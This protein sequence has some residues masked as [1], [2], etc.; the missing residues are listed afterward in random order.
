[1]KI[2]TED[3]V[4][5]V[6]FLQG[7]KEC[8]ITPGLTLFYV[9]SGIMYAELRTD[10][11]YSIKVKVAENVSEEVEFSVIIQKLLPLFSS[12]KEDYFDLEVR[13]NNL[14]L[15]TDASAIIALFGHR[16]SL[17]KI[18]TINEDL[19][20]SVDLKYGDIEDIL[21][22]YLPFVSVSDTLDYPHIYI[23]DKILTFNK[24][25]LRIC[26]KGY[27]EFPYPIFI[28]D[29][30]FKLIT[31]MNK[32]TENMKVMF[33]ENL[34]VFKSDTIEVYVHRELDVEKKYKENVFTIPTT[35]DIET[36]FILNRV[37]LKDIISSYGYYLK[38]SNGVAVIDIKNG[39]ILLDTGDDQITVPFPVD[40]I[41]EFTQKKVNLNRISR[42]LKFCG[43]MV[44][45][46]T[47]IDSLGFLYIKND[48]EEM[49]ATVYE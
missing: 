27:P 46:R 44:M 31:N 4:R 7:V 21:K 16:G 25:T 41:G 42:M 30:L 19:K 49:V 45:I 3:F 32:H 23:K 47:D 48:I 17:D 33:Y 11:G 10:V 34:Y 15:K 39:I 36:N 14:V 1:M 22:E 24:T 5:G 12:Y 28:N 43:D 2:K 13:P 40:S 20:I 9:I 18:P 26:D 6:H 35:T 37:K 29:N 8:R 38:E